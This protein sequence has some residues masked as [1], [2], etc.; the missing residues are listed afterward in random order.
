MITNY[1]HCARGIIIKRGRDRQSRNDINLPSG[2]T[3]TSFD[4]CMSVLHVLVVN[5][6]A[7]DQ[8]LLIHRVPGLISLTVPTYLPA[9]LI[10]VIASATITCTPS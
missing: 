5:P 3:H 2:K 4:E 10:H 1:C 6:R 7:A 9:Y 8:L